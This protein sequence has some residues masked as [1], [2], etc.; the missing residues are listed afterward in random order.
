M[1]E[2]SKR[3][4]GEAKRVGQEY[5]RVTENSFDAVVRSWVELNKGWTAIAAE[6]TD[7]SK[8]AFNDGD[9]GLRA[10]DR[11]KAPWAGDRNPVPI[12]QKRLRQPHGRG[13]EARQMYVSLVEN[14]YKPI[15]QTTSRKIG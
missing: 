9:P 6:V 8:S 2:E 3:M 15:E 4:A 13:I 14:A 11:R 10:G 7:Y 5:Q 12:R 1:P